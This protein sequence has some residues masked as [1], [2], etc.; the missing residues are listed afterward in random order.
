[1]QLDP[2]ALPDLTALRRRA[3]SLAM[4]DAIVSPDWEFRY[5]SFDAHWG[6]GE[7]MASMRNGSGDDWFLLMDR[8]GA[9]LKGLAHEYPLAGD[10]VF[11]AEVQRQ[12][13]P[14]F[15]SFLREPAFSME[16]LSYCY[17]RAADDAAWHKV[18]HPDPLLASADDGSSEFLAHLVEPPSSYRA[19]A[20]E[21]YELDLP[22]TAIEA[23]YGHTPLTPGLVRSLNAELPMSRARELAG[24]IGYPVATDS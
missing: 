6:E 8:A 16:W 12:V 17:W 23:V 11:A 13:P 24:E 1:M 2:G 14:A 21:Y 10:R 15:A 4:L 19:F 5:Y 20:D 3:Q 9:A 7:E 18:V 22:L